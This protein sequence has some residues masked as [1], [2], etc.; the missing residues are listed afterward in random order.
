M[1]APLIDDIVLLHRLTGI[2][3]DDWLAQTGRG[4]LRQ[5]VVSAVGPGRLVVEAVAAVGQL[6]DAQVAEA[7]EPVR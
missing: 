3:V 6:D 1:L 4:V 2:D 7:A 5:E